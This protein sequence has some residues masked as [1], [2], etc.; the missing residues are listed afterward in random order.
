MADFSTCTSRTCGAVTPSLTDKC[1]ACGARVLTSRRVRTLGWV[2][3]ACGVFLVLLMGAVTYFLYP[4]LSRPGVDMGE[5]GRWAGT[6]EQARMV[7]NLF[8]LII[9]LGALAIVGGIV[10]I[11]SGRRHPAVVVLTLLGAAVVG[12]QAW[13]TTRSLKAAEEAEE[14]SRFVQPPPIAPVN[15]SETVPDKPR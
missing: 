9:A 12:L 5:A 8:Y 11:R 2:A 6:A 10:Q 13:Q 4:T 14:R 7:L 1:P 15:L 3:L